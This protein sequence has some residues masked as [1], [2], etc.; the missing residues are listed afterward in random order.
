MHA[1]IQSIKNDINDIQDIEWS[2]DVKYNEIKGTDLNSKTEN[3]A[4]KK[5]EQLKTLKIR[6]LEKIETKSKIEKVLFNCSS[7]EK[8]LYELKYENNY[9]FMQI[10]FDMKVSIQMVYHLD[11]SLISKLELNW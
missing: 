3:I 5:Q 8:K 7:R 6:L 2:F 9:T 4:L 1:E 10:S 11:N